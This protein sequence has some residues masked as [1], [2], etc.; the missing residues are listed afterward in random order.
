MRRRSTSSTNN[1]NSH[2]TLSTVSNKAPLWW[3]VVLSAAGMWEAAAQPSY[4]TACGYQALDVCGKISMGFSPILRQWEY[5]NDTIDS[6]CSVNGECVKGELVG[7]N[8]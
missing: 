8:F 6:G 5:I 1:S 4:M 2:I 3:M 7:C